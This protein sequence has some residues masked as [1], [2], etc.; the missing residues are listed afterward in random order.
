MNRI[1]SITATALLIGV[2]VGLSI[3]RVSNVTAQAPT[4]PLTS[5]THDASLTGDGTT[6]SPLGVTRGLTGKWEGTLSRP[7]SSCNEDPSVSV[8]FI[9]IELPAGDITGAAKIFNPPPFDVAGSSSILGERV[10]SSISF[11][12][13]G[14]GHNFQGTIQD[15]NNMTGTVSQGFPCPDGTWSA[16]RVP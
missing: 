14:N 11:D 1:I 12:S 16:Q 10:G 7:I 13:G 15:E 5:V 8:V 4:K 6:N 2:L 3:P 9:F